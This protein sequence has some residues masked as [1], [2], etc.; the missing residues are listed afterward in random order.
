MNL[1]KP[2]HQVFSS[3]KDP[4]ALGKKKNTKPTG[5]PSTYIIIISLMHLSPSPGAHCKPPQHF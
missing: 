5:I 4:L 1:S 3:R 2:F